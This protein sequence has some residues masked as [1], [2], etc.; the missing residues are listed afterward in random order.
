M[1]RLLVYVAISAGCFASGQLPPEDTYTKT[2]GAPG[3][4]SGISI[5][6]WLSGPLLGPVTVNLPCF[7]KCEGDAQDCGWDLPF[8]KL[9]NNTWNYSFTTEGFILASGASVPVMDYF[10]DQWNTETA[11]RDR[12]GATFSRSYSWHIWDDERAWL[13]I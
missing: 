11:V 3:S 7:A 2:L 13:E 4:A 12:D 5:V 10:A 8:Q 9:Y 6:T 1:R